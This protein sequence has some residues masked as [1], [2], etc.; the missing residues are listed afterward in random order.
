MSVQDRHFVTAQV[1][2]SVTKPGALNVTLLLNSNV[3][4]RQALSMQLT[5][6]KP[7]LGSHS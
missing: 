1:S 4:S 6:N 7:L 3:T 2:Q 5:Q